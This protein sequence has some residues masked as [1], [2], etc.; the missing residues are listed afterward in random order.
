MGVHICTEYRTQPLV[1]QHLGPCCLLGCASESSLELVG[2]IPALLFIYLVFPAL[3]DKYVLFEMGKK[4]RTW[5]FIFS[6]WTLGESNERAGLS[7]LGPAVVLMC[8]VLFPD[9]TTSCLRAYKYE[10]IPLSYCLP[11]DSSQSWESST[12]TD[13]IPHSWWFGGSRVCGGLEWGSQNGPIFC[14]LIAGIPKHPQP[15][16]IPKA[17]YKS[18]ITPY[19]ISLWDVMPYLE[20][21]S[22]FWV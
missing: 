9:S 12:V 4:D 3:L 10:R 11:Y 8:H 7:T 20:E 6:H 19:Y 2:P 22:I 17:T 1:T 16:S 15:D 18:V 21:V 14:F 13:W 5:A